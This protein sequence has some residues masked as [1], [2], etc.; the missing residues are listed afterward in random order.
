MV[1][2]CLMVFCEDFSKGKSGNQVI[3]KKL[4]AIL[5]GFFG[6]ETWEAKCEHKPP[7]QTLDAIVI[8]C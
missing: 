5:V 7:V 2:W 3:I 6:L 4:V 1:F 8:H